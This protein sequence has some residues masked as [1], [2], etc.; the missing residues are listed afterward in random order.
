MQLVKRALITIL[1]RTEKGKELLLVSRL[2]NYLNS[3]GWLRSAKAGLPQDA[4]SKPLP[5]L[6]YPAIHFLQDRVRRH[7]RVFEFGAGQSTLWWS[8]QVTEVVACEH[9]PSWYRQ[10]SQNAPANV[11]FIYCELDYGG[12]YCSAATREKTVF[13]IIVIDGRDRV[14]CAKVSVGALSDD[15]VFVWD[16]TEREKYAP[17]IKYLESIG[18]RRLDF[19]GLGPAG[20]CEWCTSILYRTTNCLGI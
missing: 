17:G 16:N 12:Q 4:N 8:A 11:K 6:T 14:N 3:N 9:N 10:Y 7:F 19:W 15:G 18:F 13:H 5:W 1:S 2:R 20:Y